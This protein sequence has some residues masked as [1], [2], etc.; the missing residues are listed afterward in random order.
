MKKQT[1]YAGIAYA[2][3]GC[4]FLLLALCT[5]WQ[6]EPLFWGLFGAG[7][8]SGLMMIG[9]YLYW[10]RRD[11][12]A[13]YDARLKAEQINLHD[14]RKIMLRDKSGAIVYR[15]MLLGD[16]LLTFVCSILS[17]LE[18]GK[19]FTLYLTITFALL[20]VIQYL[21]GIAVFRHLEK[22]L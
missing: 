10:A 1:L 3:A 13:A 22:K 15:T 19:P 2:A 12:R 8:S 16:I 4:L 18:I 21:L 11:H 6:I 5:N 14:E 20:A 9:K 7:V 17:I